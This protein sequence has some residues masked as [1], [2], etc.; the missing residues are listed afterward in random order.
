MSLDCIFIEVNRM[1]RNKFIIALLAVATLL[2]VALCATACDLTDRNNPSDKPTTYTLNFFVEGEIIPSI[3]AAAGTEITPPAAPQKENMLFVGW[4][5]TE[6]F[7]GDSVSLPTVMP[8]ENK[9]YYGKYNPVSANPTEYTLSFVIEGETIPEIIAVAGEEITPPTAPQKENML[10]LGWFADEN[11]DGKAVTLPTVMPEEDKIYYGKYEYIN[12]TYTDNN[13]NPLYVCGDTAIFAYGEQQIQALLYGGGD[14]ADFSITDEEENVN[15]YCVVLDYDSKTY[16]VYQYG[17]NS[18]ANILYLPHYNSFNFERCLYLYEDDSSFD[19]YSETFGLYAYGTFEAEDL[20][21]NEYRLD[22]EV[23]Y[24]Y[25][26]FEAEIVKLTK[27][28][29]ADDDGITFVY[30]AFMV[31]DEAIAGNYNAYNGSRA[32]LTL[33]GYGYAQYTA[34]NGSVTNG[35]ASTAMVELFEDGNC[36][37]FINAADRSEQLFYFINATQF[38]ELGSELGIYRVWE[39]TEQTAGSYYLVLSGFGFATIYYGADV[40]YNP[41]TLIANAT[42]SIEDDIFT[43]TI[44]EVLDDTLLTDTYKNQF[45]FKLTT[46]G[47]GLYETD[48]FIVYNPDLVKEYDGKNGTAHITLNDCGEAI[49][50]DTD[51]RVEGSF[52]ISEDLLLILDDYDNSFLFRFDMVDGEFDKF[53]RIGTEL[54]TYLQYSYSEGFLAYGIYL[55]GDGNA[56][57]IEYDNK[58]NI[59]NITDGTYAKTNVDGNYTVTFGNDTFT[60]AFRSINIGSWLSPTYQLAYIAYEENLDKTFVN[61]EETLK[62]DGFGLEGIYTQADGTVLIGEFQIDWNLI[63]FVPVDEDGLPIAIFKFMINGDSFEIAP[64]TAG[65]FYK[66][67]PKDG[68][69][70]QNTKLVLDGNGTLQYIFKSATDVVVNGTYVY[71]EEQNDYTITLE[72]GTTIQAFLEETIYIEYDINWT[73]RYT[74]DDDI[75]LILD[76]YGNVFYKYDT[77]PCTLMG[78]NLDVIVFTLDKISYTFVLNKAEHTFSKPTTPCGYYYPYVADTISGYSR[79]FLHVDGSA[80]NYVYN[81]DTFSYELVSSGVFTKLGTTDNV[82]FYTPDEGEGFAF[83]IDD[84]TVKPSYRLPDSK[85]GIYSHK[86]LV[87]GIERT[88]TIEFDGFGSATYTFYSPKKTGYENARVRSGYYTIEED[89][90]IKFTAVNDKG[91]EYAWYVF[92]LNEDDK[93]FTIK[94]ER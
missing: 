5:I 50:T 2:T 75:K 81:A 13:D 93:T 46:Y 67:N 86:E 56:Q 31:Y 92:V 76:G 55:D 85:K 1:K 16:A 77:V 62:L 79:L 37:N 53:K 9:T 32:R 44:T 52:A 15:E 57:L 49:Y 24:L 66:Y 8:E 17:Y 14:Y 29:R 3:T 26:P 19:V 70:L 18:K 42:Y 40:A 35:F 59:V 68:I 22:I 6:D 94:S 47:S 88:F 82:Y 48:A 4:F 61:G 60:C 7:S 34:P 27:V 64:E 74:D 63:T 28:V 23:N 73:G 11:F 87:D 91:A 58:D 10:F 21:T 78:D 33:D 45:S 41:E 25:N 39:M 20:S 80:Y 90:T 12:D 83:K 43:C 72:N 84:S 69:I 38:V 30:N 54:G 71:N 51:I 36:I 89:G 65:V